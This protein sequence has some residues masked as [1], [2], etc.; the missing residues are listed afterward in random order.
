MLDISNC[1]KRL[2]GVLSALLI[3]TIFFAFGSYGYKRI[4]FRAFFAGR[5][6]PEGEL[7]FRIF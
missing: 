6:L 3:G 1:S 4:A 7:A 2:T 5:F